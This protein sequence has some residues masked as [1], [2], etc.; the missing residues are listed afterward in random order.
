M[1]YRSILV[2]LDRSARSSDRLAFAVGLAEQ[3]HAHLTGLYLGY[4]PVYPYLPESGSAILLDQMENYLK[5]SEHRVREEF[6]AKVGQSAIAYDWDAVQSNRIELAAA[7]ARTAD[8]AIVGQLDPD[9]SDGFVAEGFPELVVMGS[10]RPTLF[11]PYAGPVPRAF[12]RVLL[13]WNGSRES[14]RAVA[15]ALP[16]LVR[17]ENVFVLTVESKA[18]ERGPVAVPGVDIATYL[19]RHGVKSELTRTTGVD[20]SAGEWLLSRAA[21]F[22]AELIVAGAYGHSRVREFV[23]GGATRTLLK[24]MT[25]PVLMSH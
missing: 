12:K 9:D 1:D 20:L 11:L 10:G 7:R 16:L 2:C 17:A 13:A 25:V 19:S 15:D 8:I 22:G 5:A 24:N 18:D 4:E 6:L 3:H 21:D 14:A 23:L